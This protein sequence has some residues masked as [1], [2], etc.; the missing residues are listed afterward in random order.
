MSSP[1]PDVLVLA[2]D[3]PRIE[4]VAQIKTELPERA[5]V[6]ADLRAYML[7]TK[8][9]VG[10]LVTLETTSIFHDT[11]SSYAPESIALV[12]ELPTRE[13]LQLP[14][15][16][17]LSEAELET[18][19]ISWLERLATG[20]TAALPSDEEARDKVTEHVLPAV[21]EGRVMA[22]GPV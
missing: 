19:L 22:G 1:G 20:S 3:L 5:E 6:E 13:L 9:A 16:T 14:R 21:A 8:C 11:F 4:L 12:A 7:R 15:S 2:S 18:A 17:T 10:L